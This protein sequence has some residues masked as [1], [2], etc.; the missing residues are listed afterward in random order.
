MCG[1]VTRFKAQPGRREALVSLLLADVDGMPGCRS[2]VVAEGPADADTIWITE[3][4]QDEAAHKA[5]L[6]R[7]AV[8]AS[9]TAAM[10]LIASFGRQRET[11]VVGGYG[12]GERR[13]YAKEDTGE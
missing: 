2:Y 5:A 9:I 4:W 6:Q 11:R 10:P 7:P 12:L 3:V 8:K 1:L 13:G